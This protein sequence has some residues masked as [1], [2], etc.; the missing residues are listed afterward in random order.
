MVEKV[1]NAISDH[2]INPFEKDLDQENLFSLISGVLVNEDIA[3]SF[4]SIKEI[5]KETMG[6]F[7][8]CLILNEG[9]KIFS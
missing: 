7:V 2:F 3:V 8:N 5:G 9:T 4:F 6:D 1:I